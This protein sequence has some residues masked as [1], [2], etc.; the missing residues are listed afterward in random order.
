MKCPVMIFILYSVWLWI[1]WS[2]AQILLNSQLL[3]SH[4]GQATAHTAVGCPHPLHN[5]FTDLLAS[6]VATH[7]LSAALITFPPG[8]LGRGSFK[9]SIYLGTL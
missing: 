6:Q 9:N 2:A 5:N 4:I 7:F 3:G 1:N 8:F